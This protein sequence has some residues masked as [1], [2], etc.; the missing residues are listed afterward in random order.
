MTVQEESILV[1]INKEFWKRAHSS[2][3]A[4]QL[5]RVSFWVVGGRLATGKPSPGP[6]LLGS[7]WEKCGDRP[8]CRV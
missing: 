7:R 4:F 3:I 5:V 2:E 1:H 6:D 8:K